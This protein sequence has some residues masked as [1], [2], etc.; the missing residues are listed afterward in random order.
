MTAYNDKFLHI[1]LGCIAL[2]CAFIGLQVHQHVGLG[3]ALAYA[4][5]TVGVLYEI[6]QGI[7]KEGMPDLFDALATASPGWLAW[8]ALELTKGAFNG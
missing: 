6:Q 2:V 4:T 7:R 1:I 8:A 3:P 5:T